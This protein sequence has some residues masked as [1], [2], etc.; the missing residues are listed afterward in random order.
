MAFSDSN[1]GAVNTP[2][3]GV[4][5][6]YY[7]TTDSISTVVASGYFNSAYQKMRVGDFITVVSSTGGTIAIDLVVVAGNSSGVVTTTNGT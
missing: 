1:L 2:L 6:W 7:T 5:S 3:A 4:T